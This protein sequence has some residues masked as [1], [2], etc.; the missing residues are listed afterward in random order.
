M[1][2]ADGRSTELPR[3]WPVAGR[4][5][6]ETARDEVR[7]HLRYAVTGD[8]QD[9]L[10]PICAERLLDLVAET[11]WRTFEPGDLWAASVHTSSPA[12]G[13]TGSGLL[14]P[15][16][17]RTT[18]NR[19]L[20]RVA[21]A[22]PLTDAT[23]ES[24]DGSWDLFDAVVG[25]LR[26]AGPDTALGAEPSARLEQMAGVLCS[27]KL[28]LHFPLLTGCDLDGVSSAASLVRSSTRLEAFA[29]RLQVAAFV[30]TDPQVARLV[31]V[32]RSQL[33]EVVSQQ[34]RRLLDSAHDFRLLHLVLAAS[35]PTGTESGQSASSLDCEP[36]VTAPERTSTC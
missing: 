26:T 15:G 10:A 7:V 36:A 32:T 20:H 31:Q 24:L 8:V 35:L 18:V 30:I 21:A 13:A 27:V 2:F 3:G 6:L 9:A 14:L 19:C 25:A 11:D 29:L 22:P 16:V 28:P 1:R 4:E 17:H 5:A 33:R 12:V 34:T 23:S